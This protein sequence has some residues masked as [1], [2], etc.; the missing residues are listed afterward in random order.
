MSQDLRGER[1]KLK[2]WIPMEVSHTLFMFGV[3]RSNFAQ[4]RQKLKT[5]KDVSRTVV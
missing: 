3:A 4:C 2:H 1:I 5:S